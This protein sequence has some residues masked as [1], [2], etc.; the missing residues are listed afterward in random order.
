VKYS[1]KIRKEFLDSWDRM[2]SF[3]EKH[4][5]ILELIRNL[6]EFKY[7]EHL[8]AGQSMHSLILTRSRMHSGKYFESI[9]VFTLLDER[10]QI[11]YIDRRNGLKK[12]EQIVADNP[13][14]EKIFQDWIERLLKVGIA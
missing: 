11:I 6:R 9:Q 5:K 8:R 4:H 7:D 10:Y 14:Q 13:M 12:E 1:E 2:E 3:F